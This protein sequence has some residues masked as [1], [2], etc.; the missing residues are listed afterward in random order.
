MLACGEG[1]YLWN[2]GQVLPEAERWGVDKHLAVPGLSGLL[3]LHRKYPA[4]GRG[5]GPGQLLC[6]RVP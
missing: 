3:G 2:V 6:Q 4:G 5:A 1:Y